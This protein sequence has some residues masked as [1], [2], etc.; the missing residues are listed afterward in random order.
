[1]THERGGVDLQR[2]EQA[3]QVLY[4]VGSRGAR[5]DI[6]P[7]VTAKVV[8]QHAIL[9][10]ELGDHAEMPPGE[11]AAESMHQHDVATLARLPVVQ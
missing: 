5:R 7:T 4:H 10:L 11:V 6:A 2:V 1:M 3:D 9:Q 8:R